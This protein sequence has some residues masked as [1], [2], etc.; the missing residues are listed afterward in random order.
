MDKELL[1]KPRLEE[2][3][4]ELDVGV[5]RVRALTRSEAMQFQGTHD[6]AQLEVKMIAIS[7]VDP[8]LSE[9][10]VRRWQDASPAGELQKVVDV[11]V[12]MSGML[13]EAGKQNQHQFRG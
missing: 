5:V 8:K 6:A 1:F 2:R 7:V 11:I 9:D 4:V 13:K 12:E 10:D 3:D